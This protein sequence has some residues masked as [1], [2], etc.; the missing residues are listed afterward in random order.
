MTTDAGSETDPTSVPG[1]ETPGS[2]RHAPL[3]DV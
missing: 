2:G 3:T 1:A